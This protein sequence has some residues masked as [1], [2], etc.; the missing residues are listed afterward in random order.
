[1]AVAEPV[2]GNASAAA[3]RLAGELENALAAGRADVLTP[4]ALQK[5][6]AAMC[7]TYSAHVEA[8]ND[9]TPVAPRSL[10]S[11]QV[12]HAAS[13]LLRSSNLA[14]FELGMW[15]SWTGR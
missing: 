7:R 14:V 9:L 11:T 2:A 4:D 10:N 5:L 6:M 1:V 13:G 3:V 12:M 15:Q 8:G